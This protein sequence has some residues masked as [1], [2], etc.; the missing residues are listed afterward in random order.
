MQHNGGIFTAIITAQTKKAAFA[1]HEL[2]ELT[3]A[4]VE[5]LIV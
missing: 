2:I 3:H 5:L 4:L 1:T